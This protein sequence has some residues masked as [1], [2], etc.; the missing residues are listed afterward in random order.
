MTLGIYIHVPFCGKK[1]GYCNFY[2]V[3]YSGKS[4]QLYTDAVIRNLEYYSDKSTLK[5]Y[6]QV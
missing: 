4:A 5:V 3:G 2:S 6:Y 1:C